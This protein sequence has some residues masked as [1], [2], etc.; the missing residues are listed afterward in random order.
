MSAAAGAALIEMA[1]HLTIGRPRYASHEAVMRETLAHAT[2]L[3]TRALG[4]AGDDV[5]AF[6]E[7][8]RA[9][10]LPKDTDEQQRGRRERIQQ[11]LL[12]ATEIP[13]DTAILAGEVIR[14]AG[15][16][17]DRANVTVLGDVAAA[18]LSGRAALE[19]ALINVEANLAAMTDPARG[20]KLFERAS[21]L[22]PLVAEADSTVRS[23]RDR[24]RG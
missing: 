19:T 12:G 2:T 13:L 4:L 16:I 10:K 22:S 1:C 20:Q 24:I 14:L 23:I 11:A 8:T 7:V 17:V 15:R 18:A 9:Y 5:R 6:T 21:A 3:R